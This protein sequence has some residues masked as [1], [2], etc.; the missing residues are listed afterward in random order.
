[1]SLQAPQEEKSL[2]RK[3]EEQLRQ[4]SEVVV[5]RQKIEAF[6]GGERLRRSSRQQG[7]VKKQIRQRRG[8][9]CCQ[10]DD[11]C[12]IKG[13]EGGGECDR[14]GHNRC[15]EC[16]LGRQKRTEGTMSIV[17]TTA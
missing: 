15:G 10:C 1:M 7:Y 17:T 11:D 5:E 13:D 9:F 6:I 3:S 16:L 8:P 12:R 14:C 4:P 2:K